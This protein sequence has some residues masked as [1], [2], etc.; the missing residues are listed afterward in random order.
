MSTAL[1]TRNTPARD[2]REPADHFLLDCS[3]GH[4]RFGDTW[5]A[6]WLSK[7]VQT[8]TDGTIATNG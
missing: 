3:R 5:E 8:P 6:H 4:I 7:I 2:L 1:G